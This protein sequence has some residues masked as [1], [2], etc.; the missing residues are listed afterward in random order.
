MSATFFARA[1]R[2]AA[3][4]ASSAAASTPSEEEAASSRKGSDLATD[5]ASSSPTSLFCPR[6]KSSSVAPVATAGAFHAGSYSALRDATPTRSR[7]RLFSPRPG[8]ES[9][10]F[11]SRGYF[12]RSA[13]SRVVSKD[14]RGA[15]SGCLSTLASCAFFGATPE[16]RAASRL[17][18][19][20]APRPSL[21]YSSV[22]FTFSAARSRRSSSRSSRANLCLI[23]AKRDSCAS[24]VRRASRAALACASRRRNVRCG[25]S[26]RA[27]N[28]A[29]SSARRR[30][31]L[32]RAAFFTATARDTLENTASVD[33]LSSRSRR[34]SSSCFVFSNRS[35]SAT[36][37][38]IRA[39]FSRRRSRAARRDGVRRPLL[40]AQRQ[41]RLFFFQRLTVNRE[42]ARRRAR[43]R[44]GGRRLRARATPSVRRGVVRGRLLSRRERLEERRV[45][46][47]F[48]HLLPRALHLR[49]E[50]R[51][52]PLFARQKVG[53]ALALSRQR[54]F[55]RFVRVRAVRPSLRR[56]PRRLFGEDR[57]V[58][59]ETGRCS[60]S[61]RVGRAA[62]LGPLVVVVVVAGLC[63]RSRLVEVFSTR[64]LF[65][66]A[67]RDFLL[68]SLEVLLF[69]QR[70]QLP[71]HV[72]HAPRKLADG[73]LR[74]VPARQN[75]RERLLRAAHALA[76]AR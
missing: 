54:G 35:A 15:A 50:T 19:A 37:A 29:A 5:D 8:E 39:S 38:W 34:T 16:T 36:V 20:F 33:L 71:L 17:C 65:F 74:A 7:P 45:A 24:R 2:S 32:S 12:S 22:R 63:R 4:A 75:L 46:V 26:P 27:S 69:I 40:A 31:F 55:F 6:A 10:I 68:E 1:R 30:A 57:A 44:R 47:G 25:F 23:S 73:R 28:S 43:L 59:C 60:K 41:S 62:V 21:K 3:S 53:D 70:V 42:D 64:P 76:P 61:R 49:D 14:S 48:V 72:L 52:L 11:G 13:I 9:S 51:Q 56:R 58:S 67:F 66:L 18:C